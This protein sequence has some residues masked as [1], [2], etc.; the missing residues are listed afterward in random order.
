L[1]GGAEGI[2]ETIGDCSR[3][4][5]DTGVLEFPGAAV[6]GDDIFLCGGTNDDGYIV[7]NCDKYDFGWNE[8]KAGTPMTTS[9]KFFTLNT[10][11][12]EMIAT[13]G[14]TESGE[15]VDSIEV[16]SDGYWSLLGNKL[17]VARGGHCGVAI[18]ET[19]ILVIGGIDNDI[20]AL[21]TVEVYS[22]VDGQMV[23]ELAS[24]DMA[25]SSSACTVIENEVVVS[26]GYGDSPRSEVYKLDLSS[27][28]TSKWELHSTMNKARQLHTMETVNGAVTVY[29]GLGTDHTMETYTPGEG[30]AETTMEGY[31]QRHA[32]VVLPCP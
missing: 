23:E 25:L 11:G 1:F 3:T 13:G 10:V 27:R 28:S 8:W 16:Y 22:I 12:K 31:H 7:S 29:G 20:N 14:W 6:L 18:S 17:T 5:R 4:V 32:S 15:L 30:W 24:L 9:R 19:E 26:G 2:S 21:T